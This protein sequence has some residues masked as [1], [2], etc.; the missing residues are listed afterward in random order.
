MSRTR[1]WDCQEQC[2]W[3]ATVPRKSRATGIAPS[4]LPNNVPLAAQQRIEKKVILEGAKCKIPTEEVRSHII[5]FATHQHGSKFLQA[6]LDDANTTEED[7]GA[8]SLW[9]GC[10]EGRSLLK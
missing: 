2:C 6:K 10:L 3:E 1:E 5:E 4:R 9:K 7:I 8:T